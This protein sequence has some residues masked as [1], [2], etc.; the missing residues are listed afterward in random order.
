MY[1]DLF[2]INQARLALS[3]VCI[4]HFM[5]VTQKIYECLDLLHLT[6]VFL[7]QLL[8]SENDDT[9]A[10]PSGV[11]GER[12]VLFCSRVSFTRRQT[13]GAVGSQLLAGPTLAIRTAANM[14]HTSPFPKS[15]T[16]K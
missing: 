3:A 11:T 8:L 9:S 14:N 16:G 4:N 12:N 1:E 15:F 6:N 5:P 2:K 10:H 13:K 7:L